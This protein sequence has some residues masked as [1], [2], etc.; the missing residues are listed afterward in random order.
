M[1]QIDTLTRS[2]LSA[3]QDK[4]MRDTLQTIQSQARSLQTLAQQALDI[5]KLVIKR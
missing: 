3:T 1:A 2:V 4:S 5:S